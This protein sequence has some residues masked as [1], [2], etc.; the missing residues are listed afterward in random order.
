MVTSKKTVA[1]IPARGGSKRIPKKN[2]VD[3]HGKPMIAWTIEA[4]LKSKIFDKVIVST[5]DN[6]IAEISKNYGATVPFLRDKHNDDFSNVSDVVIHTLDKLDSHYEEVVMLMANCPLRT[7]QDINE[8]YK[9][10]KNRDTSFQ[11]SCFNYGWLNPWWAH[12][13]LENGVGVPIFSRE[14]MPERSQDL[15]K[16]YCISGA[17][18]IAKVQDL[19]ISKTFYGENYCLSKL[20]WINS[21]DIDEYDDLLMARMLYDFKLKYQGL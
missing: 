5:D 20:N 11:L 14:S 8:S 6:E 16:L 12:K 1:I 7:Y 2:I 4:A 19:I 18:W 13:I 21:I 10:F 15:E 3:F 17:I 9:S